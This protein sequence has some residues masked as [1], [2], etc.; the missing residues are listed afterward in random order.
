M[1][2]EIPLHMTAHSTLVYPL[3]QN[4]LITPHLSRH[5]TQITCTISLGLLLLQ[6]SRSRKRDNRRQFGRFWEYAL[7]GATVARIRPFYFLQVFLFYEFHE[8]SGC[9]HLPLDRRLQTLP[10]AQVPPPHE[11]ILSP[12][13][14]LVTDLVHLAAEEAEWVRNGGCW[15]FGLRIFGVGGG[16]GLCRESRGH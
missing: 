14:D 1:A 7:D 2:L 3:L 12:T 5:F 16:K 15:E 13:V 10:M 11:I 8:F 9:Y 4:S 6:I